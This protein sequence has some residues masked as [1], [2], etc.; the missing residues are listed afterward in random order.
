[1]SGRRGV[2]TASRAS[3]VSGPS[4]LSRTRLTRRNHTRSARCAGKRLGF[5]RL[6]VE[7]LVAPARR[8]VEGGSV[9]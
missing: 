6:P 5:S 1:M 7:D 9:D 2:V 3:P 8:R 4:G